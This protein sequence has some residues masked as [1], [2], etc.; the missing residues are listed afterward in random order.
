MEKVKEVKEPIKADALTLLPHFFHLYYQYQIQNTQTNQDLPKERVINQSSTSQLS[1][2]TEEIRKKCLI[3]PLGGINKVQINYKLDKILG[4]FSK[5]KNI[6]NTK[7]DTTKL[8]DQRS[9][10]MLLRE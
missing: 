5:P 1:A 9:I 4:L 2:A 7:I 3:P 10:K 8:Q 6:N